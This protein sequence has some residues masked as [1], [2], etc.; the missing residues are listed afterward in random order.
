MSRWARTIAWAVLARGCDDGA[1]APAADLDAAARACALWNPPPCTC[2][3]GAPGRAVC[4]PDSGVAGCKRDGG[5]FAAHI[6]DAAIPDAAPPPRRLDAAP[7]PV[8]DA[9][10]PECDEGETREESC[11]EAGDPFV[12]TC[13]DGHWRGCDRCGPRCADGLAEARACPDG[14]GESTRTCVDGGWSLWSACGEGDPCADGETQTEL[15]GPSERRRACVD[16]RWPAWGACDAPTTCADGGAP[17]CVVDG[18]RCPEGIATTHAGRFVAGDIATLAGDGFA[19]GPGCV[20][21]EFEWLVVARPEG[22]VAQPVERFFDP[23]RAAEGGP[24]DRVDTP[25]AFLFLDR[26]G[27]FDVELR[28][29]DTH[30]LTSPSAECPARRAWVRVVAEAAP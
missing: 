19:D 24:A 3:D 4:G 28:V 23:A 12:Q 2:G 21:L 30:G 14:T 16:G 27:T 17:P 20:P 22:S 9:A 29:T 18:V 8:V 11:P 5:P 26:P 13:R 7:P 1:E 25:T 6:E 15:C 10:P